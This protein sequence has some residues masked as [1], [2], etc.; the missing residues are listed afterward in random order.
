MIS[1]QHIRTQ[2]DRDYASLTTHKQVLIQERTKVELS[3][4]G[5]AKICREKKRPTNNSPALLYKVQI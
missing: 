1:D 3:L 4:K 5:T 2:Y